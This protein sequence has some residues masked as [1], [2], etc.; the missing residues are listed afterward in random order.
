L[1]QICTLDDGGA[2]ELGENS[3]IATGAAISDNEWQKLQKQ[4]VFEP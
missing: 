2:R 4:L 1:E 3:V